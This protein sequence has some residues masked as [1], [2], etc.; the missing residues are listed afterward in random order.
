MEKLRC[1]YQKAG[2]IMQNHWELR[3]KK[4]IYPALKEFKH[5]PVIYLEIGLLDGRTSDW[6]MA[7]ILTHRRARLIGIDPVVEKCSWLKTKYRKR[8]HIIQGLSQEVIPQKVNTGKWKNESIDIIYIDGD[9]APDTIR[10]D[11]Y[12]CWPL[13]KKGG[14]LIFDDYLL[15]DS[16]TN[17]SRTDIKDAIDKILSENIKHMSILFINRQLGIKKI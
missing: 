5:L 15:L 13:L 8:V 3:I 14:V 17:K 16:K 11:F 6:M 2:R 4:N 10:Q 12:N 1:W 9:H 7:H